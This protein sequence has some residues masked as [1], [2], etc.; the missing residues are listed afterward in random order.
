MWRSK[1]TIA[2][3]A[4]GHDF[5][6]AYRLLS[7]IRKHFPKDVPILAL[8]ATASAKVCIPLQLL[9]ACAVFQW[10]YASSSMMASNSSGSWPVRQHVY[11]I[12]VIADSPISSSNLEVCMIW[13]KLPLITPHQCSR[14]QI[15]HDYWVFVSGNQLHRVVSTTVAKTN[16]TNDNCI[17]WSEKQHDVE[18]WLIQVQE[19]IMNNLRLVNPQ[20]ICSSFDRPNI[21]F[22]V[23]PIVSGMDPIPRISEEL[24]AYE[25][26]HGSFPCTIIY[27]FRKIDVDDA[28]TDLARL[29]TFPLLSL[30]FNSFFFFF[31]S[32]PW[33]SI[34]RLFASG[35][36]QLYSF[37]KQTDC[38]LPEISLLRQIL[39][40]CWH[41]E[42]CAKSAIL[43]SKELIPHS[44]VP[45]KSCVTWTYDTLSL[46]VLAIQQFCMSKR[47]EAVQASDVHELCNSW[48]TFALA[49]H[50]WL[51]WP[52]TVL[53]LYLCLYLCVHTVCYWVN[54]LSCSW[55]CK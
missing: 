24:F 53:L 7:N 51:G 16:S 9:C 55:P 12:L 15:K 38:V 39:A 43:F 35:I 23:R 50:S 42:F 8:T 37:V 34:L 49:F 6:P 10:V 44:L 41:R 33:C 40:D 18:A 1:V 4:G 21:T 22:S 32:R 17:C 29:G 36:Q 52:M 26:K 25:E 54:Q 45:L 46:S 31:L 47:A 5:R 14:F 13:C 48:I 28:A 2:W 11:P 27:G 19:D 20:K 3:L 30:Y